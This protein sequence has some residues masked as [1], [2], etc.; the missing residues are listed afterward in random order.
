MKN[1]KFIHPGFG[2][3]TRTT[4]KL[5]IIYGMISA[6][7]YGNNMVKT[8]NAPHFVYRNFLEFK[9]THSTGISIPIGDLTHHWVIKACAVT[10]NWFTGIVP[11]LRPRLKGCFG[12]FTFIGFVPALIGAV[13]AFMTGL[14]RKLLTAHKA[15]PEF[16]ILLIP[17]NF[18][19]VY[20]VT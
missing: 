2:F 20:I 14:I 9:T 10:T 1:F 6:K 17:W 4:K 16:R 5:S 18:S 11:V 15:V 7:T 12:V 13:L 19:H 3:V 8:H